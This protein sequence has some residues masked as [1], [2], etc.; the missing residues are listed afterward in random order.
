MGYF[1]IWKRKVE[2]ISI[3]QRVQGGDIIMGKK[4]IVKAEAKIFKSLLPF[5]SNLI[6]IKTSFW[7]IICLSDL[8]VYC[9]QLFL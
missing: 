4:P 9:F 6:G 2:Q 3:N 8:T 7:K 5:S 1:Y